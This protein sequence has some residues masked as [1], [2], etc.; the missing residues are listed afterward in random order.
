M[1]GVQRFALAI[2]Q[3]GINQYPDTA[4][5]V[6]PGIETPNEVSKYPDKLAKQK[7]GSEHLTGNIKKTF[8]IIISGILFSNTSLIAQDT[9]QDKDKKGKKEKTRI[10]YGTASFYS[11]EFEGRKTANGEIFDQKNDSRL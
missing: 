2:L 7:F 1:V 3:N 6:Q 11:N 5:I 9:K 10:L 4:V 8:L